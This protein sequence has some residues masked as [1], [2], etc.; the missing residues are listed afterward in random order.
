[1]SNVPSGVYPLSTAQ[2]LAI[3]YDVASP[4]SSIKA[5]ATNGANTPITLPAEKNLCSVYFEEDVLIFTGTPTAPT[6]NVVTPG[7]YYCK[8]GVIAELYLPKNLN[9]RGV[10]A[11]SPGYINILTPWVQMNNTAAYGVS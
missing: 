10:A 7:S 5:Q 11:D 2:S 3:P 1:M 6:N 8:G 4:I 9:I